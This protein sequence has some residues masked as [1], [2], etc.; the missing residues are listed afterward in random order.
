MVDALLPDDIQEKHVHLRAQFMQAPEAR[1]MGIGRELQAVR[2]DGSLIPV[3][4]GLTPYTDHDRQLVLVS[5]I[6]LSHRDAVGR[7]A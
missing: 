5:L 6:D 4:V 1:M 3:E 2:K 7:I